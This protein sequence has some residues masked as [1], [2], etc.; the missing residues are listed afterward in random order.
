VTVSGVNFGPQYSLDNAGVGQRD[1]GGG[2][3]VVRE[4]PLEER[5]MNTEWGR[6]GGGEWVSKV[7]GKGV[8]SRG[9]SHAEVVVEFPE[10]TEVRGTCSAGT[11]MSNFRY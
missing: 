8:G 4:G 5:E 10:K 3:R 9:V 2:E 1:K 6:R 7:Q 11:K